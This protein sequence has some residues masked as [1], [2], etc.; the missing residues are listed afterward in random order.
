MNTTTDDQ[1]KLA[2]LRNELEF[3]QD[4]YN[5]TRGTGFGGKWLARKHKAEK[6]L[7]DFM[8]EHPELTAE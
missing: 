3:C 8:K 5:G 2:N 1:Q 4:E 6:A 7:D